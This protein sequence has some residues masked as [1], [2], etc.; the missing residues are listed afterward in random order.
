VTKIAQEPSS[1]VFLDSFA[2]VLV[3]VSSSGSAAIEFQCMKIII[4]QPLL[5]QQQ[6]LKEMSNFLTKVIGHMK[7]Q[8]TRHTQQVTMQIQHHQML[9][10]AT[11][12]D[13]QQHMDNNL[14]IKSKPTDSNQLLDMVNL[15]SNNKW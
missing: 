4:P 15:N 7:T 3:L 6:R 14:Y 9:L 13:S 1:E 12:E 5:L 11:L 8:E 2:F 10:Q